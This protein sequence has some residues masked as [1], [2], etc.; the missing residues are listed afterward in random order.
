MGLARLLMA[1]MVVGLIGADPAFAEAPIQAGFRV[2]VRTRVAP[3][4]ERFTL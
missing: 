3:G 4:V 1:V 2:V